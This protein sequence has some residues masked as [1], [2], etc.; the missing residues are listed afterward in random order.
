MADKTIPAPKELGHSK[1][2]KPGE[3]YGWI[4]DLEEDGL[5]EPDGIPDGNLFQ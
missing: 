5:E 2:F 1:S 4:T 3:Q